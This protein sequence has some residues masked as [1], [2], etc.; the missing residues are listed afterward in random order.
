MSIIRR[1]IL[2][3]T[4]AALGAVIG[5]A[6]PAGAVDR[7]GARETT[8]GNPN[9]KVKVVE[10]ASVVCPHCGQ[11]AREVFPAFKRKYIDSGQVYFIFREFPTQPVDVAV[12]G[13]LTA[14][15]AGPDNYFKVIDALFAGQTALYES[16]D[17]MKFIVDAGTAG[18]LDA[19]AVRTCLQDT[20]AVTAMQARVE[21][22][23]ETI[24]ATP[25]FIIGDKTLEGSQSLAQ[26]DAVIQPLLAAR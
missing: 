9:A 26:L 19:A 13:F 16:G 1:S 4:A 7:I 14:R 3:F 6:A 5:F 25:T 23:A 11:F 12:A 21:A 18:G 10:Y 22:A 2:A 8:M 20:A 24:N 15:C 17:G